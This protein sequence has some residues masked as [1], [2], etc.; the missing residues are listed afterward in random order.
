M[1]DA[2]GGRTH[3]VVSGLCLLAAGWEIVEHEETT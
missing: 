1:L 2:L 3:D